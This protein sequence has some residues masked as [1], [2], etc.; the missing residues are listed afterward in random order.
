MPIGVLGLR[1]RN[2]PFP[3]L[4]RGDICDFSTQ[5]SLLFFVIFKKIFVKKIC[6]ERKAQNGIFTLSPSNKKLFVVM[7]DSLSKESRAFF[8]ITER[9]LS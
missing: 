1:T 6:L 2:E 3:Y 8:I 5:V 9:K 4:F 7:P